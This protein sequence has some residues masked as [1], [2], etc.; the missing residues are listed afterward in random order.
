MMVLWIRKQKFTKVQPLGHSRTAADAMLVNWVSEK[1]HKEMHLISCSANSCDMNIPA[2]AD[3][4]LP[5]V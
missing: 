3:F 1:K 2:M 4:K 5:G